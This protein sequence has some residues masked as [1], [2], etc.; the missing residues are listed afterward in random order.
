LKIAVG[1]FTP[2]K[3]VFGRVSL[4]TSQSPTTHLSRRSAHSAMSGYSGLTVSPFFTEGPPV[5][6]DDIEMNTFGFDEAGALSTV[7]DTRSE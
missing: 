3:I 2:Q 4:L 7:P 5:G 1:P 6:E